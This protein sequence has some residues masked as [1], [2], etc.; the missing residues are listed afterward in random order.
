[1]VQVR[2]ALVGA[3]K[4]ELLLHHSTHIFGGRKYLRSVIITPFE[5]PLVEVVHYKSEWRVSKYLDT[6]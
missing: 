1:M 4:V 3:D 6:M 5:F 2:M